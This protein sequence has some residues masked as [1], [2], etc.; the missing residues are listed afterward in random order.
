MVKITIAMTFQGSIYVWDSY[1]S[2]P[3]VGALA[4]EDLR[5]IS[6]GRPG[7]YKL[8]ENVSTLLGSFPPVKSTTSM[9][10]PAAS[11]LNVPMLGT[12]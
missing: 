7:G 3:R 10:C 11:E 2:S 6:I 5:A 12:L 1:T 8:H 9:G 4:L